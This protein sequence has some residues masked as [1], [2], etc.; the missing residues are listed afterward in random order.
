MNLRAVLAALSSASALFALGCGG[1]PASVE[2]TIQGQ[3]FAPIEAISDLATL[4]FGQM[5]F[6]VASTEPG[7]CDLFSRNQ[8]HKNARFLI[9]GLGNVDV[10]PPDVMEAPLHVLPPTGPNEFPV[11]APAATLVTTFTISLVSLQTLD[12]NC[13]SQ[14]IVAGTDGTVTVTSADDLAFQ[15]SGDVTFNT[16]DHVTFTFNSTPCYSLGFALNSAT[17]PTCL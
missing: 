10:P 3:P 7:T 13:M 12:D 11:L 14:P 5:A 16:G 8:L 4:N 17:T 1:P 15:G 6:I 2:G 9:I